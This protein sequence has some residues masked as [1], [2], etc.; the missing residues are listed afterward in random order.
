MMRLSYKKP[1]L[2]SL[3]PFEQIRKALIRMH[4]CCF[5]CLFFSPHITD[6]SIVSCIDFSYLVIFV[7]CNVLR[8][9]CKM[10]F[11][12]AHDI[13]YDSAYTRHPVV[14]TVIESPH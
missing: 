2:V 7:L 8:H 5:F 11:C 9:A 3:I 1:L 14:L 6:T 13:I 12:I 10:H 4:G